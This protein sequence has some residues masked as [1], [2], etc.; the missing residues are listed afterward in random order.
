MIFW[1]LIATICI[2]GIIVGGIY[3]GLKNDEN[4]HK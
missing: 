1:K 3:I 2:I 4:K